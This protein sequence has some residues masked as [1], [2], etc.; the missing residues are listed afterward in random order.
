MQRHSLLVFGNKIQVFGDGIVGLEFAF[1]FQM[2]NRGGGELFGD[3]ADTVGGVHG[4]A[5]SCLVIGESNRALEEDFVAFAD[6][7][8]TGEP[9]G[10]G[11]AEEFFKIFLCVGRNERGGYGCGKDREKDCYREL[12]WVHD[13]PF[14]SFE[15]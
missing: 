3:G 5:E 14:L 7:Y 13:G 1:G 10:V 2:E 8:C 15:L 12:R 11:S 6:Q 9:V 4:G